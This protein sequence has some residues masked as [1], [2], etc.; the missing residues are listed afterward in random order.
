MTDCSS[1]LHPLGQKQRC[2]V[3]RSGGIAEGMRHIVSFPPN[4]Q[5]SHGRIKVRTLRLRRQTLTSAPRRHSA[6]G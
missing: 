4:E 1:N 2:A 5:L 6:L 3:R